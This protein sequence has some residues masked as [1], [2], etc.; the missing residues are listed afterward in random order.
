MVN[1]GGST[2][3]ITPG[4]QG[5]SDTGQYTRPSRQSIDQSMGDE[6]VTWPARPTA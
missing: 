4:N 2:E 6:R 1:D 3:A 5:G